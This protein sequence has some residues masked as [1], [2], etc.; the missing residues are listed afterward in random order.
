MSIINT[1]FEAADKEGIGLTEYVTKHLNSDKMSEMEWAITEEISVLRDEISDFLKD[2]EVPEIGDN[3]QNASAEKLDMMQNRIQSRIARKR[4][5]LVDLDIKKH[6]G[7]HGE[8]IDSE[9][10]SNILTQ[11]RT[12]RLQKY[13]LNEKDLVEEAMLADY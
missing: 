6:L 1:I 7:K 5:Q 11:D 3:L 9:Y 2:V 12:D 4:S 13:Q 10:Q 8:Y